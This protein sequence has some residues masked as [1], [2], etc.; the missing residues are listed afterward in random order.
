[1]AQKFQAESPILRSTRNNAGNIGNP[2]RL[3]PF[4]SDRAQIRMKSGERI[5]CSSDGSTGYFG[6]QCRFTCIGKSYK[7]HIGNEL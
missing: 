6:N 5:G 3:F 2:D 7:T 1:M 4:S